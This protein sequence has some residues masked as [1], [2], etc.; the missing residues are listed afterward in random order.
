MADW[1]NNKLVGII[2]GIV[3][4]VCIGVIIFVLMGKRGP[5]APPEIEQMRAIEPQSEIYVP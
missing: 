4:V 3:F 1:K 5:E 2:A